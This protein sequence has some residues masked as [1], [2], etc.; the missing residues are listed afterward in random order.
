M[1][2]QPHTKPSH[3]LKPIAVLITGG[4]LDKI[5]DTYT[6]SLV[7]DPQDKSRIPAMLRQGRARPVRTENL[8]QIDSL[9]MKDDHRTAILNAVNNAP[10]N[11]IIITHGTG[12]MEVT[13]QYL[14]GK[15]GDKTVIL[16]G[17][18]R[19][20]SLGRS[21]AGFNFGGAMI[22]VQTLPLGVY[23]VM[24]GCVFTAQNLHKNTETGRFDN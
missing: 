15:I 12:T 23:G 16:T 4:T 14:E 19:P 11:H 7:F 10:E 20:Q 21:D 17:A 2:S 8:F 22:A 13:A 24:N 5:H 18:M 9:D 1:T 3:D 6:E